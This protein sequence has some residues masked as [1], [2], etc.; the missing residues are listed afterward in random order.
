M[1][2][3]AGYRTT[4][5]APWCLPTSRPPQHPNELLESRRQSPRPLLT[6]HPFTNVAGTMYDADALGLTAQKEPHDLRVHETHLV[7]VEHQVAR[8]L[9]PQR[10]GATPAIARRRF[11]RSRGAWAFHC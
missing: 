8:L 11:V 7:Q 2:C 4:P 6:R 1:R 9:R 10:S 5:V 3:S